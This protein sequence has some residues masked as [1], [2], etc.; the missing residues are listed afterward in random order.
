[1]PEV[2]PGRF[3]TDVTVTVGAA[4]VTVT[5]NCPLDTCPSASVAVTFTTFTPTGKTVPEGELTDGVSEPPRSSVAVT[6]NVPV[7]PGWPLKAVA[8]GGRTRLVGRLSVG[9]VRP[10]LVRDKATTR[11]RWSVLVLSRVILSVKPF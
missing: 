9:A 8:F 6:V 3:V 5:V 11:V 1:M 4:G 7:P 2:P 10:L